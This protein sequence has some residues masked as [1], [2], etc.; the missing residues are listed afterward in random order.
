ML[1]K[2]GACPR[3]TGCLKKSERNY[4]Q[5][6]QP[7]DIINGD[8]IE[9][10][11]NKPEQRT[12][13]Y[14]VDAQLVNDL[15]DVFS[16]PYKYQPATDVKTKNSVTSLTKP[17]WEVADHKPNTIFEKDRGAEYGTKFHRAMQRNEPFDEKTKT[18]ARIIDEFTRGMRVTRELVFLQTIE[19]YGEPVLVQ[20]VIDLL[21]I[22][23]SRAIIIDYKT[24]NANETRLVELYSAQLE[25]YA[26]A[27]TD[28]LGIKPEKY[29]YSTHLERL[30]KI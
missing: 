5:W 12:L 1:L 19:Q 14:D 18:C 30:L 15:R 7:T 24:T 3:L 9:I 11:E 13:S 10:I 17:E 29:I 22:Y 26:N 23:G 20:G 8:D 2:H 21:A 4:M 25:M 28:A 6:L 27:V 16:K